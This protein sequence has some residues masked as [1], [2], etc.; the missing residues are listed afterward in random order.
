MRRLSIMFNPI[1]E[2]IL[3]TPIEST[4]GAL[5][6]SLIFLKNKITASRNRKTPKT[7][8]RF[9]SKCRHCPLKINN[10]EL[11]LTLNKFKCQTSRYEYCKF[12]CK[13]S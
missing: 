1:I 9:Y 3:Y 6:K 11:L 2:N 8:Q 7:I 4:V 13:T 12:Y 10:L 5:N